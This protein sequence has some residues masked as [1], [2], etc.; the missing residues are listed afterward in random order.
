[1]IA[2]RLRTLPLP[3]LLLSAGPQIAAAQEAPA[4]DTPPPADV[5]TDGEALPPLF[6]VDADGA[7]IVGAICAVR[8]PWKVVV[9]TRDGE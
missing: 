1:M 3:L 2:M 6:E 4:L 5:A 9:G 7:L 8:E